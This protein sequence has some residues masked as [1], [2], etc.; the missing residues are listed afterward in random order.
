MIHLGQIA[1]TH[2]ST[3]DIKMIAPVSEIDLQLV[4]GKWMPSKLYAEEIAEYWAARLEEN[5]RLW[6]GKLLIAQQPD[7]AGGKLSAQLLKVDF[8][9][10]LF[11]KTYLV[12]DHIYYSVFGAAVIQ[13]ADGDLLYGRMAEHTANA[14]QVYPPAGSLDLNDLAGTTVD[15]HASRARE[16]REE[17]GLDA[18]EAAAS[19]DILVLDGHLIAVARV[20]RFELGTLDLVARIEDNFSRMK[21]QE[22]AEM[23]VLRTAQDIDEKVNTAYAA[24]LAR[25]VLGFAPE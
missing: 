18:E 4:S 22:L 24:R 15:V 21:D 12:P 7:F 20:L 6:N 23:V 10:F 25:H 8:A 2:F 19:E 16:L 11:W 17:T 9:S 5:P 14:G 1:V 3:N 13:S